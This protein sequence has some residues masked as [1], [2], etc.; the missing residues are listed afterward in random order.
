MLL[1]ADGKMMDS[2]RGVYEAKIQV[3]TRR[4]EENRA[5]RSNAR[6]RNWARW[7]A[8]VLIAVI[9]IVDLEIAIKNDLV[10]FSQALR[11]DV[12]DGGA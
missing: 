3:P 2:R 6:I 1:E 5:K 7:K 9:R 8:W 12:Y 11:D 10:R 4:W